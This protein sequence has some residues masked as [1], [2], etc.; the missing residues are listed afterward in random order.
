MFCEFGKRVTQVDID[1]L[2]GQSFLEV[3]SVGYKYRQNCHTVLKIL[4]RSA[5]LRADAQQCL[6]V[7][8][9]GTYR[10]L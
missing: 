9:L 3:E 7:V 8:L 5:K 6:K 1:K 2:A 4:L 10:I